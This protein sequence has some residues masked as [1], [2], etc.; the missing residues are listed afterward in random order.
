MC[1]CVCVCVCYSYPRRILN[2][3]KEF[4]T[5][6]CCIVICRFMQNTTTQ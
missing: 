4:K 1:V 2:R 5:W 6:T 3:L